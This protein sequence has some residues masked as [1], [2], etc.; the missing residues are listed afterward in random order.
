MLSRTKRGRH[1]SGT[2]LNPIL[3]IKFAMYLSPKFEYS[4]IRFVYDE[5]VRNRHLA[6]DNYNRLTASA[7]KF[8]DTNYIQIAKGLNWVVF[9]KHYKGIREVATESQLEE[10]HKL[11]D[12]LSFA[13]DMGLINSYNDLIRTM[14]QMYN[15]K[16]QKF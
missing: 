6:G 4:V 5:L 14:R 15:Q 10:L 9:N 3:F 1:N 8:Y 13:I 11:E 12:R 16:Y 2:W 7:A